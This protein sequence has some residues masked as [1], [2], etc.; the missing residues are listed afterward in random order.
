MEVSGEKK[1]LIAGNNGAQYDYREFWVSLY[2]PE[3]IVFFGHLG[4]VFIWSCFV[5][6][7]CFFCFT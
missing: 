4:L 7:L 1:Y 3:S 6:C 5:F 2:V